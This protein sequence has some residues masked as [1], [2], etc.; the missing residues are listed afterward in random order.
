VLEQIHSERVAKLDAPQLTFM[1]H[2]VT[3]PGAADI[4]GVVSGDAAVC[5]GAVWCARLVATKSV[6]ATM[7]PTAGQGKKWV[8]AVRLAAVVSSQPGTARGAG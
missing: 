5:R 1:G 4:D 2:D 8:R 3:V 7:S 6:L